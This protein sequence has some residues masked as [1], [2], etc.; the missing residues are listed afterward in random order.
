MT[1]EEAMEQL[2]QLMAYN[3]KR[4]GDEP[5]YAT[6]WNRIQDLTDYVLCHEPDPGEWELPDGFKK[7]LE[8]TKA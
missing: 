7:F 5:D 2:S 6:V 8:R 3:Y 4:E 1:K